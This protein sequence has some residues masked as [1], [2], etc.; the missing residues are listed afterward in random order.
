MTLVSYRYMRVSTDAPVYVVQVWR[1]CNIPCLLTPCSVR[2][3]VDQ[4][5]LAEVQLRAYY[6]VWLPVQSASSHSP[7]PRARLG[8]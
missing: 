3:V 1:P 5:T 6:W 8:V 7:G 4:I 2:G